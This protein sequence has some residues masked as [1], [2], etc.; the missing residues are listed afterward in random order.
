MR[1]FFF[2]IATLSLYLF[3]FFQQEAFFDKK[4]LMLSFPLPA[5]SQKISLGYLKQL[6][7]E[8][9]FVKTSVFLGGLEPGRDPEDYASSLAENFEAASALHPAFIDTYFFCQSSLSYIGAERTRQANSI[10]Q[11]G[12]KALPDNWVLPFFIG[13]NY[14]HFLNEPK[15]AAYFLHQAAE[16]PSG[17]QIL[18][19][20]AA[21]LAAE[22]GDI[23]A[24]LAWLKAMHAMEKD[25]LM[26]RRYEK[27]IMVFEKAALVLQAIQ[28]YRDKY[29]HPPPTLSE[30]TPEFL[31]H[32]PDIQS[33][34][35][36]LV[37]E[38]PTLRLV[39][40]NYQ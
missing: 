19:S 39:H 9:L 28:A 2:L 3:C 14:F 10:L 38:P 17:P 5:W 1:R 8:I 20:L 7:A 22:G 23:Y 15:E 24:G 30:L 33:D 26:R 13:F 34:R 35:F 11:N 16:K 31:T 32:I 40:S 29:G 37:W 36:T 4:P 6:G 27:R 25:E 18:K 12:I 21:I